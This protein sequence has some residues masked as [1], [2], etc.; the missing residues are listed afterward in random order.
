[1]KC[2]RCT[3][4]ANVIETRPRQDNVIRRRY[5]CA[6]LHRF[7]T[8]EYSLDGLTPEEIRKFKPTTKDGYGT[9]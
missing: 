9:H 2:P 6:N 5:E 8:V 3:A 1:M 7:T 4:W